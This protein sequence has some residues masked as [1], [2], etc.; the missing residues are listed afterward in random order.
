MFDAKGDDAAVFGMVAEPDAPCRVSS[1]VIVSPDGSFPEP[2]C[3]R[4]LVIG[5]EG[6]LGE[7]GR[8]R[9]LGVSVA[10]VSVDIVEGIANGLLEEAIG[11]FGLKLC[12]R[13]LRSVV[14]NDCLNILGIP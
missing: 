8:D 5:P 7:A 3:F 10:E 9:F 13:P 11:K 14:E 12:C 1:R 2:L 6:P 4:F